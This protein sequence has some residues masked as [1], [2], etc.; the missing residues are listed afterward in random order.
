MMI[1]INNLVKEETFPREYAEGFLK[2]LNP[3]CPFITEELWQD[4][5]HNKT[6]AYESWPNYDESKLVTDKIE[7]PI[8]VN[9]KLRGK[10]TVSKTLSEDEIKRLATDEVK[11]YITGEIKKIIYIPNRIFNIVI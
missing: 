11:D 9:G 5:G 7:I 3:V 1:F 8:Q 6:I 10:I 4:L 2:L